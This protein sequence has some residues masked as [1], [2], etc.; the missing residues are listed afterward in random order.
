MQEQ[1]HPNLHTDMDTVRG[2]TRF[3]LRIDGTEGFPKSMVTARVIPDRIQ[4]A[5]RVVVAA[6][7]QTNR[8]I[9][10]ELCQNNIPEHERA[11]AWARECIRGAE[12]FW[13]DCKSL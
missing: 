3:T 5:W 7:S 11:L 6:G 2:C 9:V 12:Q 4:G 8:V 10:H 1:T 13:L